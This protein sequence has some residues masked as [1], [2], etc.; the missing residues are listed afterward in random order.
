[1]IT[2][3]LYSILITRPRNVN[4]NPETL[5]IF[6]DNIIPNPKV[7]LA[8]LTSPILSPPIKEHMFFTLHNILLTRVKRKGLTL[9]LTTTAY[10]AKKRPRIFNIYFTVQQV[11]QHSSGCDGKLNQS[12]HHLPKQWKEARIFFFNF[13]LNFY[14]LDCKRKC[15]VIWLVLNFISAIWHSR[16]EPGDNL[17]GRVL[18]HMN[19]QIRNLKKTQ[20][21]SNCFYPC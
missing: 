19:P 8:Y 18:A 16:L 3:A 14:I 1:M 12:T 10:T 17:I 13:T 15:S 5:K 21:Y 9:T 7:S 6:T 4:D 11:I 20:L 2:K